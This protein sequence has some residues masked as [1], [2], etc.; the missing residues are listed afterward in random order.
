MKR[1]GISTARNL[2]KNATDAERKLWTL[3]R[4]RGID[5][6]KFRRQFPLNGYILDF[7]APEKKLCVEVDGSGHFT[8]DGKMQDEI[9]RKALAEN[10][11]L[12]LRFT[13]IEVLTNIEGVYEVI[14]KT[15]REISKP[16]HLDPLP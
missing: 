15:L 12:V 9:R 2:R 8:D 4:S 6:V 11:I 16:P 7:Y 3:L 1:Q 14:F 5:G 13:N 10:G